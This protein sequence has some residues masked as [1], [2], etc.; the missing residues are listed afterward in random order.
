MQ[1]ADMQGRIHSSSRLSP[2]LRAGRLAAGVAL[3]LAVLLQPPSAAAQ[4]ASHAHH[5]ADAARRAGPTVAVVPDEAGEGAAA[6]LLDEIDVIG[7]AEALSLAPSVHAVPEGDI[8]A[9]RLSAGDAARLFERLPGVAFQTGGGVS[10]LPVVNGMASDRVLTRVNGMSITASCG[11]F[12][13]P[14]L[15]YIDPAAIADATLHAG[16]TPVS[17]G[18]DSIAGTISVNSPAP[19]FAEAGEGTV[20]GGSVSTY[21]RSNGDGIGGS[22]RLH[23]ATETVSIAYT[24]A[25]ARAR[26]YRDGAGNAVPSTLFQA[27]NHLFSA[28]VRSES[29]RFGLD[30]GWQRIPYQGFVNQFMDMTGNRSVSVNGSYAGEFD[31]GTLSGRLYHNRVRHSMDIIGNP[32]AMPMETDGSDTGYSLKAEIAAGDGQRVTLGHDYHRYRL[33]DWWPPVAGSMMMGPDTFWNVR[34]GKRDRAALYGEVETDWSPAWQTLV[35]VRYEFVGTD[36]GDVAGYNGGMMYAP[37]AAAFNAL[38]RRREDH[39]LDLTATA[40]YEPGKSHVLEF[41]VARKTRSPNLYERYAWSTNNMASSMVNWTGDLNGYVG[42]PDL[43]PEVAHTVRASLEWHD[44]GQ[45]DWH[46]RTTAYYTRVADYIGVRWQ[47]DV[48]RAG[49]PTQALLRFANHDAELYGVDVE[50]SKHL[51]HAH[52]DWNARAAFSY[53]RGRDLD[54]GLPLY[55]IMPPTLRLSLEHALGNWT[56]AVELQAVAAKSRVDP[57]RLEQRTDAYALVNLRTSYRHGNVRFD[58]G[59]DNLL[60]ADHH[61]PLGGLDAAGHRAGNL[62]PVHGPGRSFNVGLTVDF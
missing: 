62:E 3:P 59:I 19:V 50:G 38:D 34:D 56:S 57:V 40:R 61:L 18:G 11:N 35:G 23:Q 22:V 37:D 44:A 1:G 58:F 5:A 17:L 31:W 6:T 16:I 52:G 41:G 24:G 33:D 2:L 9:S 30:L 29:H 53:V 13:N 51:G 60:D 45:R 7:R 27:Q 49:R 48:V 14:P 46:L 8:R 32:G 12:M 15:S 47:R 4:N 36:A 42:N 10:S 28:A 21:Y 54:T 20:R 55:N 39:N 26:D 25:G 43:K